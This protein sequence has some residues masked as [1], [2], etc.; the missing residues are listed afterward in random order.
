MVLGDV[1]YIL[2]R[3]KIYS[4]LFLFFFSGIPVGYALIYSPEVLAKPNGSSILYLYAQGTGN[5]QCTTFG[6]SYCILRFIAQ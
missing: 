6:Y 5:I 3:A 1:W 4:S 2:Y